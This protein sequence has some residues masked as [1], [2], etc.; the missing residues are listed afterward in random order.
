LP[1]ADL[2][3]AC[4]R[5]EKH[6]ELLALFDL[7]L[8]PAPP[9]ST[10]MANMAP[11]GADALADFVGE[12]P[13][14]EPYGPPPPP[15]G[16]GP[17]GPGAPRSRDGDAAT[18]CLIGLAIVTVLFFLID[19][20]VALAQG[21]EYDPFGD[22]ASGYEGPTSDDEDVT[23]TS[24]Q[25]VELAG[26]S[27]GTLILSELYSFQLKVWMGMAEG[28]AFLVK[29]GLVYPDELSLPDETFTQFT[30]LGAARPWPL[31]TEVG[32]DEG[33]LAFP[34]GPL[35][36]PVSTASQFP[37]SSSPFTFV[38]VPSVPV[39]FQAAPTEALRVWRQ[40]AQEQ[41]DSVNF[42]LDAD[43]GLHSP[44][45]QVAGK[46]SIGDDPVNVDVLAY[47]EL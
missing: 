20:L 10:L 29:K 15:T 13:P 8:L 17:T 35:E 5:L 36:Q 43:R 11:L 3:A 26:S 4:M 21:K 46:T 28:L 19:G 16:P 12:P 23:A 7:P 32:K 6:L 34:S 27:K 44:C 39:Q 30:E 33:Y 18:T 24:Q 22:L 41:H 25:L 42:D 38:D 2:P 31:R 1:R 14:E 40:I 37:P 9:S 47:T 45:W